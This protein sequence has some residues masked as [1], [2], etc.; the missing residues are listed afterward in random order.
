MRRPWLS[1]A[2]LGVVA[3]VGLVLGSPWQAIDPAVI[4]DWGFAPEDLRHGAWYRIVTSVAV[5]SGPAAFWKT[6]FLVA[7]A[8]IACERRVGHRRAAAGFA[9]IHAATLVIGALAILPWV[10]AGDAW[11]LRLDAA[12]DVGPSDGGYGCFG[13]LLPGL[14]PAARAAIAIGIA[15]IT[16]ANLVLHARRGDWGGIGGDAGHALAL[17]LGLAL[18]P[19][20]GRAPRSPG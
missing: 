1:I 11:A 9:I 6:L 19:W 7:V 5:T 2:L 8:C 16:G 12:S 20:L 15:A 4:D 10:L 13:L 14:R 18:A 17:G 3:A